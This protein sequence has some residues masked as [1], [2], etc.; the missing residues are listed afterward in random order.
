MGAV[1]LF[2]KLIQIILF[3]LEKIAVSFSGYFVIVLSALLILSV[4]SFMRF[5]I[6]GRF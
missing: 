1:V 6:K 2:A 4:L 3:L 5:L